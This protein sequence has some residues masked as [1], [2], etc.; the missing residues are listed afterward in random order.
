MDRLREMGDSHAALFSKDIEG[1][2]APMFQFISWIPKDRVRDHVVQRRMEMLRWY[3]DLVEEGKAQGTIR[4][5]IE[6]DLIVSELFAWIWWEDLSYLEGL[7]TEMTLKG[8]ANMFTRLLDQDQRPRDGGKDM[9]KS[10]VAISKGDDPE[11]M[12][13]EV[14]ALLG[15][16]E[17]L[18]RPRSTVVLKPNAGHPAAASTSVNTSPEFVAAVIREVKKAKP[19][20]IIVAEAAA[21]GCDSMHVLDVSGIG[22]AAEAAG[23]RLIDIKRE[24]DLINIPIRDARSD[25]K[26]VKLPRFLLEAEHLFNLPI[27]KSHASMVFTCALKNMKGVVQD[28]THQ[29]MHMTDLAAAMMDVWSVIRADLNIADLIRPAEGFGPHTTIPVDFGCVVASKDPVALDATACRMVGLGLDN[30]AVLRGRA[31][32]EPGELRR[33]G[34]RGDRADHRGGAQGPLVPVHRRLRHLARVHVPHQ[35]RLLAVA[36]RSWPSPWRSSRLWASTTR[37]PAATW[38]WAPSATTRCRRAWIRTT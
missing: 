10:I 19:K 14:F 12:V 20:E 27:F 25:L 30:V 18:V 16:V 29:Q 24:K 26:K 32:A 28:V 35:R 22:A 17:N 15:G 36:S 5:D 4:A 33:G 23:A 34:H 8:S 38:W 2:N 3:A 1:F 13:A 31:G 9:P 7:D 6:T 11:K 21:I 37:T